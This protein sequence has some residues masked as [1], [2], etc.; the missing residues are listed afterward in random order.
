MIIFRSGLF[1]RCP[2]HEG[3]ALLNGIIEETI[4]NYWPFLSCEDPRRKLPMNL[5]GS[6]SLPDTELISILISDS[7]PLEL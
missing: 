1:G 6:R 2:S 4:G 7:Q 5:E 3:R